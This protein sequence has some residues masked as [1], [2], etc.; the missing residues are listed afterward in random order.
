MTAVH[1]TTVGQGERVVLVH[2]GFGWAEETFSAQRE[3]ADHFQLLFLDRRGHGQSLPV[4]RVDFE[5]D[6][7]DIADALGDGAHLVGHS[8]GGVGSLLAAGLNPSAVKT[9]TVIEPPAFGLARGNPS[10]EELIAELS[11][12][13][14]S[15]QSMTPTD[16]YR[17]FLGAMGLS[18]PA[19]LD[20]TPDDL[21]AIQSDITERPPWEARVPLDALRRAHIPILVVRGTWDKAPVL[22][23]QRAGLAFAAVCEVL[24]EHLGGQ[25]LTFAGASHNPQRLG[26]QFN[27]ALL[28]FWGSATSRR[29]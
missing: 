25:L 9:L 29:V 10:V 5:V 7:R 19:E 16:Y 13:Y 8:Y 3:L 23:Q 1:V 4:E 22:A 18:L 14:S 15:R 21:R 27:Q 17:A 24:H 12:V 26:P 6:A 20:L 28:N 2:G 11:R